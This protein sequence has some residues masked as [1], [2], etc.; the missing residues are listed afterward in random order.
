MGS[1]APKRAT[2]EDVLNAPDHLVAEVI[3]GTLH[4]QPRP[5]LSHAQAASVLGGELGGPFRSGRGGPGGWI[6]LDGP[7]LHFAEDI[8]V[9][10]L[11]GWRRSTLPELPDAAFLTVRTD[12]L[13]EVLSPSTQ[14][15][16]RVLKMPLYR[17][18][19]VPHV[20]L[21]DPGA[22]TLEVYR[23]DG[24]N[25]RLVDT[26]ADDAAIRAEPFEAIALDLGALWSK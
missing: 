13:C 4:T 9:P 23:L 17:R 7:E 3:D 10:D 22:R 18:E 2:Y 11:A 19:Q 8:V 16:D 12:W 14:H 21:V 25:Y 15:T 20:W 1:E 5:R 24:A 26:Y 6:L